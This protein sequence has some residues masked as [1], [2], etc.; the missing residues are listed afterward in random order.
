MEKYAMIE[1]Q[2]RGAS[3]N[4]LSV[5]ESSINLSNSVKI[6]KTPKILVEK[7]QGFTL[8]EVLITLGVIGIIAA[9][10]LPSLI[11]NHRKQVT[12][13]KVKQTYNILNNALERAKVDYDTD[14][15]NWYI[16]IEG[17]I[18]EKSMFFVEK[19]MKPYLQVLHYCGD[20]YNTLYCNLRPKRLDGVSGAELMGPFGSGYGTSI[21]L[22]NGVVVY[23]K[24]GA[25]TETEITAGNISRIWIMFDIDGAQGFN[26][27]GYD[28]FMIELGGAEGFQKTNNA[29]RNKFLPYGYD[30]SK[31]CDYYVSDINHACNPN[32]TYSGSY[33][34][35]YIVCNGWDFGDKYPW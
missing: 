20:K 16:P 22:N 13:T 9:M 21:V 29:N 23:V 25:M 18:L 2:G 27:L 17:T 14:I 24:V 1:F 33:C 7:K 15:N 3:C 28:V 10:T 35:A 32:S 8:A 4:S 11:V 34:L 6:G 5:R 30:T 31:K 26:K 12:L 19:Y